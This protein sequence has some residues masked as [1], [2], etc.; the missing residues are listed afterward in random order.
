MGIWGLF[1]DN[2]DDQALR[3]QQQETE[4]RQQQAED[5]RVRQEEEL[6]LQQRTQEEREL[7]E[8]EERDLREQE[9]RERRILSDRLARDRQ[10]D[11]QLREQQLKDMQ[12][13]KQQAGWKATQRPEWAQQNQSNDCAPPIAINRGPA[14][15]M[16]S[17]RHSANP[18]TMNVGEQMKQAQLEAQKKMIEDLVH[19]PTGGRGSDE[20]HIPLKRQI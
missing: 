20:D 9:E 16:V 1:D 17:S 15:A 13:F 2:N 18:T 6:R 4:L 19:G 14:I 7:R 3:Q 8:R 12:G 10:R 5:L 11:R